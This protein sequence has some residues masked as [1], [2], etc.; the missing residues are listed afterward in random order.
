M[1]KKVYFTPEMDVIWFATED[2]ITVSGSEESEI[3]APTDQ[4][5]L[6]WD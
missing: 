1:K 3:P 5:V 6:P 2:V 4:P